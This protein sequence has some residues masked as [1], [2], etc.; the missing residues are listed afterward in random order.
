MKKK[1]DNLALIGGNNDLPLFAFSSIKKKFKTFIYINISINNKKK[2]PKNR[3][4]HNL[5]LF[6]LEK[7]ID[8]LR[9][10]NITH[11]CFLGSVS[12]PDLTKLKLDK[13]LNKYMSSLLIAFSEG[14][15]SI[16]NN[17][18][19]IFKNE[20]FIIKSFIDVFPNEYLLDEERDV[21][22][23]TEKNDVDKGVSLLKTLS[24]FD[25]AQS[26]VISNGYILAIEAVEGTDKML[27]RINSIKKKISRDIV[28]GVLIKM[29]KTDQNLKIDL[30]AVG[31]NTLQMMYENKLNVLAVDKDLTI[32]VE[33]VKFYKALKKYKIKLYF[34]N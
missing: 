1:F 19:N 15:G 18:V 21:L 29:P 32:V 4:V 12:R 23:I 22:S 14:D 20:G 27:T 24:N 7:C 9:I 17:I 31:L 3:F 33:K 30:P 25:N 6:E 13:I 2:L 11:I 5:K 28:E 26:C 8:L 34:I 16:L 10:N